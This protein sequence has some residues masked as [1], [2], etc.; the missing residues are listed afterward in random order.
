[1]VPIDINEN[2]KA[3]QEEILPTN[4][5]AVAA[6]SSGNYPSPPARLLYLATDGKPSGLT[7]L[8]IEWILMDGQ[9]Y[10]S[11]SGYIQ[12]PQDQLDVSLSRVR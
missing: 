6:I 4:T 10:V 8:F 3:D 11:E 9:N 12:L 5:A 2:G 7:Q 1:M